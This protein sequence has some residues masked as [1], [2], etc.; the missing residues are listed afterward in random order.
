ML[1]GSVQ[2]NDTLLLGPD[3]T[4]LFVPATIKSIH[5]KRQPTVLAAS[6]QTAS[7]CLKKIKRSAI[8]KVA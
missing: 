3:A 8:R 4:G 7:F 2:P 6:G 5:R 1:A